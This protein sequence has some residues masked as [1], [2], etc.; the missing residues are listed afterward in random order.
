MP[1]IVQY[2]SMKMGYTWPLPVAFALY[3]IWFFIGAKMLSLRMKA[4]IAEHGYLDQKSPRN[5]PPDGKTSW[6]AVR[7]LRATVLPASFLSDMFRHLQFIIIA[8]LATRPLFV[9]FIAY[10]QDELPHLSLWLP[11]NV[12]IY[13][14]ILDF[15]F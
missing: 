14:S 7:I 6:T 15:Y 4:L 3:S 8:M 5:H 12:F 9:T 10:D 2:I 1:I 13:V 11:I